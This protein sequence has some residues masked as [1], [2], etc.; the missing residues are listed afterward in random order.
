MIGSR[1]REEVSSFSRAR[2]HRI[3]ALLDPKHAA[4]HE[5]LA[6]ASVAEG[7]A[8]GT[9]IPSVGVRAALRLGRS[10]RVTCPVRIDLC[11]GWSDT[12]P[13][14][15]E[16]GGTVVNA[17]I[18]LAGRQPV[19]VEARLIEEPL[20]RLRSI[21]QGRNLTISD[22][23]AARSHHDPHD[24][25]ALPK[26]ALLL[27]GITHRHGNL[28]RRLRAFGGG[29]E[30]TM[31]V[32]VP[33]G[34]GLGTSSILGAAVLACLDGVCGKKASVRSLI[35]RTSVLEQM[36]STAGGWQDQAGGITP[37]FKMLRTRAGADQTPRIQRLNVPSRALRELQERSLLYYTGQR[38]LAKNILQGV[39]RRYLSGEPAALRII[40][41]LKAAAEAMARDL[42]RGD[43]N[44]FARGVLRN[45]ELKKAIDPGSTNTR[46]EGILRTIE[47]RLTG[48]ELAGAGGGGFIF[49]VAR[50]ARDAKAV[51]RI[52]GRDRA[53]DASLVEF[54]WDGEGL[55]VDVI[56]T[57]TGPSRHPHR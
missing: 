9:S 5:A 28:S 26:A 49:L 46:I 35:E 27:A 33:K 19:C 52:L 13:I 3:A 43:I 11:G 41:D 56:A 15:H 4:S 40:G 14:C 34:S 54:A 51:K 18:T 16:Q 7:V 20:I 30:L 37:G 24:W 50:S 31:S 6:F 45:W 29:L 25:A 53:G 2:L 8:R 12:P 36:M 32:A 10:I 47:S 23:L 55:R 57:A 48:Y 21:D 17:A 39:V 44:A 42:V 22:A 1:L 38:R